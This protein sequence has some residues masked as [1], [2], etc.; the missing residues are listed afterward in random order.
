MTDL[1]ALNHL[2]KI[3]YDSAMHQNLLPPEKPRENICVLI[4][5]PNVVDTNFPRSISTPDRV[6]LHIDVLTPRGATR[7]V[8]DHIRTF[9]V[10]N[11][12]HFHPGQL[13]L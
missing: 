5:H 11:N 6:V 1:D 13:R 3:R 8:H 4:F 7:V 9:V 10:T 12:I 2:K